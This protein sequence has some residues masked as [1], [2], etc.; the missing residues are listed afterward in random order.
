MGKSIQLLKLL[1]NLILSTAE[2]MVQIRKSTLVDIS[3]NL[4]LAHET[5]EFLQLESQLE[6]DELQQKSDVSNSF[7]HTNADKDV[8]SKSLIQPTSSVEVVPDAVQ[9]SS[10]PIIKP[11]GELQSNK[12]QQGLAYDKDENNLHIPDYSK[13][14]KFISAIFLNQLQ[15]ISHEKVTDKQTCSQTEVAVKAKCLHC[16]RIVISKINFLI[17]ILVT[18]VESQSIHQKNAATNDSQPD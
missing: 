9:L 12:N 1:N 8:D 2:E 18:I 16:Q 14:I 15:S 6:R 5:I 3:M 17:S 10:K 7:I 4:Q 13:P 11:W